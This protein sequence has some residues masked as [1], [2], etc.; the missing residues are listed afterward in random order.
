[1]GEASH[2]GPHSDVP[3]DILD[4]LEFRLGRMDSD[5]DDEPL[6]RPLDGR[7]VV[8]RRAIEDVASSVPVTADTVPAD[9]EPTMPISTVPASSGRVRAACRGVA[10]R[11]ES[12][13]RGRFAVLSS[14][15]DDA[16]QG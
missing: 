10:P 2:P 13:A 6:F 15:D 9:V 11:G 14:D 4:D 16:R 7:N 12:Q 5:S 1:M 3:D 8:P